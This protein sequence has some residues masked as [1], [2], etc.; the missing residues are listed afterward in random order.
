MHI[1]EWKVR[2]ISWGA[3]AFPGP[4]KLGGVVVVQVGDVEAAADYSGSL[5]SP[6][7]SDDF[8]V[9]FGHDAAAVLVIV[10]E[11]FSLWRRLTAE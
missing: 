3:S 5:I 9:K 6:K 11:I 2:K 1:F 8:L 10:V 7:T 4:P